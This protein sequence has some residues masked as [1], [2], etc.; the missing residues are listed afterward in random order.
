MN[1]I[2]FINFVKK[3]VH[4]FFGLGTLASNFV[5]SLFLEDVKGIDDVDESYLN[6]VSK[7]PLA[8]DSTNNLK[9]PYFIIGGLSSIIWVIF[10][11][12][13]LYKRSNKPHPTR[14]MDKFTPK[15]ISDKNNNENS[16]SADILEVLHSSS[17]R[18]KTS[19]KLFMILM[20]AI[21]VH[22][23]YGIEMAY[24]NQYRWQK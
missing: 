13:Y 7:R 21:F 17:S 9:Y 3:K 18:I 20:A 16:S 2:L 11:V 6:E 4:T 19:H 24:G 8:V 22:S 14:K 1:D 10:T 5:L 23:I 12:T 15:C